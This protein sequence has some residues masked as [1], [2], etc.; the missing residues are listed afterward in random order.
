MRKV[1]NFLNDEEGAT[2]VEYSILAAAIAAVIIAVVI[3][4]GLKTNDNFNKVDSAW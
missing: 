1:L 3:A 2:G 4:I